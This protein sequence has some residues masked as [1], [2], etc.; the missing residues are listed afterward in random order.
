LV[1]E[2]FGTVSLTAVGMFATGGFWGIPVPNHTLQLTLGGIADKP[3]VVDGRVRVR[4]YLSVTISIDHDIVDGGP[5]ARFAQKLKEIVEGGFE[6]AEVV[7][8]KARRRRT[9]PSRRPTTRWSRPGQ[10]R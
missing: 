7:A 6:L 3:G 8:P 2:Y 10:L 5:A 1:K 4:E 9:E